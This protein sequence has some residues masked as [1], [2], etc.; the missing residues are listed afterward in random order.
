MPANFTDEQTTNIT[1]NAGTLNFNIDD[2]GTNATAQ[3]FW[4]TKEGLTKEDSWDDKKDIPINLNKN[5]IILEDLTPNKT[6]FY[7]IKITN[8]QGIS[9]SYNT[10]NFKTLDAN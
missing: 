5:E 9:W 3:L 6:Y 10:L 8:D 4:G 2:L 1:S 7:R